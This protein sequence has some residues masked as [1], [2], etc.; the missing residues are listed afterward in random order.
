MLE[1]QWALKRER[2]RYEAERARRQYNEVEPENRLVARSLER[3][4]ED[5]LR[6]VEEVEQDY[7]R[8]RREQLVS[9]A[10][11]DRAEI[12]ALGENLPRVWYGVPSPKPGNFGVFVISIGCL[13]G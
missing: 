13:V 3:A 2:A 4:W 12:L 9:V 11:N 8:W 5:K 1:H 6:R 7:D 10:E